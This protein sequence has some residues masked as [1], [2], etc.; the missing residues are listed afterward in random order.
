MKISEYVVR[1][2]DGSVDVGATVDKFA[3]EL[4]SYLA[5][6]EREDADIAAAVESVFDAHKG[7]A[8]N[9]PALISLS[10]PL[11]NVSLEAY[12]ETSEK[13]AEFVRNHKDTY[14]VAKGKG[15]GVR[16]ICDIPPKES[17]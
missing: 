6:A 17:K 12:T 4:Q 2:S 15:G 5:N 7:V 11:L 14:Q 8:I 3:G 10:M 9:M 13:V 1:A 16:R